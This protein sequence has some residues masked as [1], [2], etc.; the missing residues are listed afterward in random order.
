MVSESG[1][2]LPIY[3]PGFVECFHSDG[4]SSGSAVTCTLKQPT[5]SVFVEADR[6]S[7]PIWPCSCWG[8]PC[9]DC[10]QPRG[11]LLPRHFT[12]A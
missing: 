9:R 5:R 7:L 8:L 1:W 3:K 10:Y 12:L 4:H 2:I 11:E 6:L